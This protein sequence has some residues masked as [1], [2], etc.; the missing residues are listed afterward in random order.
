MGGIAHLEIM[1]TKLCREETWFLTLHIA[2]LNT[3]KNQIPSYVEGLVV[4]Y[5]RHFPRRLARSDLKRVMIIPIV[6]P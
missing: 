1:R 2:V 6:S 3:P 5:F 4:E